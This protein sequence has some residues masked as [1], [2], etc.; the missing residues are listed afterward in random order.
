[1]TPPGVVGAGNA[2]EDDV[3]FAAKVIL[4]LGVIGAVLAWTRWKRRHGNPLDSVME[5]A[6]LLL[7]LAVLILGALTIVGDR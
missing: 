5:L 3:G 6:V 7:A 4:L 1:M 2:E